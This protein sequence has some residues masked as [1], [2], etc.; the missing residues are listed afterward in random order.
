MIKSN[1]LEQYKKG[2]IKLTDG[3]K[4]LLESLGVELS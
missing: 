3:Q 2:I 1:F 4:A